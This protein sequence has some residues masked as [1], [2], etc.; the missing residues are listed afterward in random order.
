MSWERANHDWSKDSVRM[1]L[2]PSVWAHTTLHYVQEIGYFRTFDAYY[3]ERQGLASYLLVYTVSGQGK[4]TYRNHTYTL[5]SGDLFYIDC[6]EYQYYGTVGEAPWEMLWVHWNGGSSRGYYEQFVEI[7]GGPVTTTLIHSTFPV[8]LRK[9]IALQH[10]KSVRTELLTSQLLVDL[11]TELLLHIMDTEQ[12]PEERPEY[13]DDMIKRMKRD[14]R[15]RLSLEQLAK[16]CAV[17]K[18]H[19]AKQ[20]KRH[21]GFSPGEFLI[22]LRMTAAKALLKETDLTIAEIADAVG[23]EHVSHFINLFKRRVSITPLRFR[24][25]WKK[26]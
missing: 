25:Q 21:T 16:D 15:Q 24:Q 11:M 20:F 7:N 26:S 23:I 1:I 5:K 13:I 4:L 9:L 17:N 6:S 2:T 10:E 12:L 8:M 14:Y 18:Y 22:S 3:T 19:L